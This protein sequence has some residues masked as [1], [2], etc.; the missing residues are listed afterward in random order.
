VYRTSSADG[1]TWSSPLQV[2][3]NTALS[4]PATTVRKDRFY[5]V[6]AQYISASAADLVKVTEFSYEGES[7]LPWSSDVIIRDAQTI[8]SSMHFEYDSK[9][10]ATER[11]S[12]DENGVQT[13]KIV[14]TYNGRNQVVRQDV[15][16]GTSPEISYSIIAGY[17]NH[18]NTRYTRGPEGAEHYY[19]YANTNSENL[20]VD[21]KGTSIDLFSNQFYTNTVPSDC[22]TLIVGEAT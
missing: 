22:H 12:K 14:Y 6:T 21:S 3:P 18:G 5:R 2:A 1:V 7:Q 20:F 19:S 17:D 4:D 8:R 13:E 15:Y 16:A 11:I 10:R 9:G